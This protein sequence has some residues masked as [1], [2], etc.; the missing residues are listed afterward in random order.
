[1][2]L[3]LRLWIGETGL[4]CSSE[5]SNSSNM[6]GEVLGVLISRGFGIAAYGARISTDPV[7]VCCALRACSALRKYSDLGA[8]MKEPVRVTVGR[9]WSGVDGRCKVLRA[10]PR[11]EGDV[12]ILYERV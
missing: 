6:S 12:D 4:V 11:E 9:V 5:S 3:G 8:T 7:G 2:S 10:G 1:V